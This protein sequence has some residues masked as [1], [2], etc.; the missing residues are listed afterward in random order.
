M[1]G[2]AG[3][4]ARHY[5][6][7]EVAG[8]RDGEAAGRQVEAFRNGPLDGGSYTFVW[9]DALTQKVHEDGRTVIVHALIATGVNADGHW[10]I[11]VVDGTSNEDA[12][13]GWRSCAPWWPVDCRG[14]GGYLGLPRRVARRD[15]RCPA[16]RELAALIY[17]HPPWARTSRRSPPPSGEDLDSVTFDSSSRPGPPGRRQA[18][19]CPVGVVP[20]APR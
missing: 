11:L 12:P 18:S 17:Q 14:C 6:P 7:V 19:H 20:R 8:E 2:E 16:R 3:R 4:P 9:F 5:R 1:G 10:E 15:R 13:A